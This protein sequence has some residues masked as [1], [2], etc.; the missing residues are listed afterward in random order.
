MVESSQDP[1]GLIR[2]A[3]Q[4]EE[5]ATKAEQQLKQERADKHKA[6]AEARKAKLAAKDE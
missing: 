5:R 6:Q 4:A 3:K 2:K 1:Q